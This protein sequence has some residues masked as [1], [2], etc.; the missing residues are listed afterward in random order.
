MGA[1][2]VGITDV[3]PAFAG[4]LEAFLS[5]QPALEVT[6]IADSQVVV[7]GHGRPLTHRS[8]AV[9]LVIG[10]DDPDEM[11]AALE[12]G[13]LGYLPEDSTLERIANAVDAVYHGEAVVPPSMLGSLLR[14]VVHRRRA[15]REELERLGDLT[16]REREVFELVAFGLDRSAIADRLYISVGTVRSHMQRLF[17]KLDVHS[18]AEAVA[19][20]ARCGLP[21]GEEDS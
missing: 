7:T 19:L 15:E 18:Q 16:E 17:R 13:A 12:A 14:S 9:V 21:I 20:A 2:K 10:P 8:E 5:A 11:I 1:I 3:D 4:A 6:T